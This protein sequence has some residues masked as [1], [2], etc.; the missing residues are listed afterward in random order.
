MMAL[1][2]NLWLISSHSG[3]QISRLSLFLYDKRHFPTR[4]SYR[5]DAEVGAGHQFCVDR[6]QNLLRHAMLFEQMAESLNSAFFR[7]CLLY[8]SDAADE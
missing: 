2:G 7:R 6:V 4:P 8:T 3:T 1:D 5:S